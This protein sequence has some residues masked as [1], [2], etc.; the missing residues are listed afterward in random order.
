MEGGNDDD[1]HNRN[2]GDVSA[3]PVSNVYE[4]GSSLD[5]YLGL[6][7][8]LS[9]EK[10]GIPPI[11]P[12][13]SCP[14]HAL[15]FPQRMA[16]LLSELLPTEQKRSGKALDIG[17]AVG[18]SAF[19]LA[20]DFKTVDAFDFS[21]LFITAARRMQESLDEKSANQV[22][23]GIPLEGEL[24]QTVSACRE[25]D[26]TSSI[27]SR[28]AF[29]TGDACQIPTMIESGQLSPPYQGILLSNLLCRL[30]NP[31]ACLDGLS[32]LVEPGSI[33]LLVTPFSWLAEFTPHSHWLGGYYTGT[34]KNKDS[35]H[36]TNQAVYSKPVLEELMQSR[37]FELIHEQDVPLIIREHQ[38]KYQYIVSQAT[39]W[40]KC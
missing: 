31:K 16:H 27:A 15:R 34:N 18:G 26:M 19:E 24:Y 11:L 22:T 30:P 29:F 35:S 10:E 12:H 7:Y 36:P 3:S 4:T 37:G 14:T 5:M 23:F 2:V 13:D 32:L 33:V 21:E 39:A 20:K 1:H 9:G 28:V 17:C 38:R 40:R 6:H 8:P 25:K